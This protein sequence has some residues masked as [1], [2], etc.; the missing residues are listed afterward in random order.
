LGVRGRVPV[1]VWQH[2]AWAAA[3]SAGDAAAAAGSA[4]R[5]ATQLR[6]R[7]DACV[8]YLPD[9]DRRRDGVSG[10]REQIPRRRARVVVC[11]QHHPGLCVCAV[12][13]HTILLRLFCSGS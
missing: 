13:P 5:Q 6:P 7:T 2:P 12:G 11:I 10:G 4:S 8:V 1:A 3:A 9:S